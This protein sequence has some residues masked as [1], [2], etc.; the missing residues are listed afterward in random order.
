MFKKKIVKKIEK[1][2]KQEIKQEVEKV[3]C[4][5]C[6][7]CGGV[8]TITASNGKRYCSLAHQSSDKS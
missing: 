1:E 7:Y 8:A 4:D 6:Q 2:I 3:E 5:G